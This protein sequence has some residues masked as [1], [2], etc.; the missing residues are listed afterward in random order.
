[1]RILLS[2]LCLSLFSLSNAQQISITAGSATSCSGVIE[3]S[4]GPNGSYS[5]NENFTLTIC[6]DVPGNVIY[7]T[8]FVFNLSPQGGPG[9]PADN[10]T[11]YDGDNTSATSL[12]SYT[13]S[14]LQNLVVSGTV[15]NTS[16]CLTLVFRSNSNG[17]GDF[18][19]GFQCTVP[20]LNPT[21]VATMPEAVPALICQGE[22]VTF[23][24]T[25]SYA[26]NNFNI[27][28]YLWD[29]D[30]GSV[31][32]TSGPVV[33]HVFDDDGEHVVQ[34]YVTDD[35]DCR[36]LNLNDL[37]ILVSTTP[38]FAQTDPSIETCFG[39]TVELY[40][41]GE[42]TTWTGIPDANFGE[43][44]FLPDD[45]GLPFT[46]TLT[47]EQFNFGQQVTSLTDIQS[48]CVEMEHTFM[49]DLV[50]QVICP[51]GQSMIFHQQGGGGTYIGS[52]NDTD[53]ND[54]PVFGECW[55]YCWSPTATNGTWVDNVNAGGMTTPSGTP[56][57]GS[58]NPGTYEPVQT[59]NNLLGCPLNG[60]WTY[61][62]TDLWGADNGFICSWSINFNPDIIPD[63]TTF[64]PSFGPDADSSS[65]SGGT[66]PDL[67][68]ANGDNITF[69]ATA[70]GVY[71]FQY[72]VTDNFGCTYDTTITVTINDPFV[73][74]PGE[75][76]VICS[77]S[78]QLQATVTGVASACEW[79]L[80]MLD[81]GSNSWDGASLEIT[82][83]GSSEIYFMDWGL[84]QQTVTF[85]VESGQTITSE[86]FPSFWSDEEVSYIIRN[87]AGEVVF[88]VT[89]P[90]GGIA[91]NGTAQCD[92]NQAMVWSWSPTTGLSDPTI[93]N[94]MVYTTSATMYVVSTYINGHPVCNAQ[95]S[96]FVDIDPGLN[97]GV[98]SLVVLCAT[99][100][101]YQLI[102]L[103]GGTP[104]DG[105]TWTDANGNEV[106]NVFDPQVDPAG[107]YTYTLVTPLGCTGTADVDIY[108]LPASDP[109]CC[110]VADAGPDSTICTLLYQLNATPGNTGVGAWSGPPGYTFSDPYAT[111]S[112]V[113]AP[114]S[115]PAM[116]YWIEDD[117]VLCYL[118]DSVTITFTRPLMATTTVTDAIC[119]EACDG[120]ALVEVTG[121]NGDFTYAW[122]DATLPDTNFIETFC[123]GDHSV[124]IT[125]E[126]ACSTSA[127]LTIGQP[128]LLQIDSVTHVMPWC[129]G[130]ANG[131]L[132]I[133]DAEAV[134]YSSDG[135]ITYTSSPLTAELA[136]GS[137]DLRIR[138]AAGCEGTL[139]HGLPE[140]PQ[141]IAEFT[142]GP[143]PANVEAPTIHFGNLSENSTTWSWDI[144]GLLTSNE[145]HPV[146]TFTN[147]VPDSYEV[148]LIASDDHACSDTICHTVIID[149]VLYTYI[150]NAFTPDGDG[151]N[152][153]WGTHYNIPDMT[154][155][156]LKVFDRWGE[157]VFATTD[158]AVRWDGTLNNGGGNILK[159]DVYAYR[160][161]Y[162]LKSTGGAREYLGHVSLLK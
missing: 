101:S 121:G 84:A 44:I 6:P 32:S 72:S 122:S 60:D 127:D 68:S 149:D 20:C 131:S 23:D 83:D 156:D 126:N 69:T 162:Q 67:I 74:D 94:P 119:F 106:A 9:N 79:T 81:A 63:V 140:P 159:Q 53:S 124:I 145:Q 10:V 57:S 134:E 34:L 66:A 112:E 59:F 87:D 117:G 139:I 2:A 80:E 158:P 13:G 151:E 89:D 105:G 47:F 133:H 51:N 111:N 141:V 48:I 104:D 8:W 161:I 61:Q 30:D 120:T 31:D 123:A 17:I 55:E 18:A 155:Y 92:P 144:A 132:T 115:G 130:D 152:E 40:G 82:V 29:F 150:P 96:V 135:G 113:V 43:G 4:G 137:Y 110:G 12:G 138:N 3:D 39:E 86:Y 21:A 114:D 14:A 41:H 50:L 19:A 37:Q 107:T 148:C 100:P 54:N 154:G 103:L 85:P 49:G 147:K 26:Q 129:H 116:F 118:I 157:V 125:D 99:P 42:P 93:S 143:N 56:Q 7:L 5:D 52:P 98:D 65:W 109:S 35:N 16:G 22:A 70:P 78:L 71:P 88:Q 108:I 75:D 91:F 160:L 136:T 77:D 128:V 28:Q 102:D 11:I 95:D 142:H 46:S 1:M 58:I 25:G 45:V 27:V 15:F 90:S 153:R 97:P 36:N 38:T 62:S 73:L 24:G 146:Y 33:T 76:M 64:T